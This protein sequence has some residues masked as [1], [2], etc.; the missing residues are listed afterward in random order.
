MRLRLTFILPF[1]MLT[2]AIL[3][4]EYDPWPVQQLRLIVFDTYQRLKP[5]SFDAARSPVRVIDINDASLAK[6]G[7]W[8]W[9]RTTLAKMVEDLT[10]KGAAAIAFDVVFAEPDDRSPDRIAARLPDRPE[11]KEVKAALSAFPSNDAVFAKAIAK[12]RVVLAFAPVSGRGNGAVKSKAGFAFAGMNPNRFVP[13]YA[14]AVA[15]LPQ[16]VAAATG[17]GSI[18]FKPDR[19][20]II[21]KVPLFIEIGGK[22]LPTLGAEALRVAQGAPSY[23]IKSVGASGELSFGAATGVVAARIGHF[24]VPTDGT[25]GVVM[26]YAPTGHARIIPAWRLVE[27][28]VKRGEVEGRIVFI[29]ASAS[30]LK[31]IRASALEAAI[32]GVEIQA[33]LVEQI[34]GGAYLKVPDFGKGL[35]LGYMFIVG[36]T[37]LLLLPR[38]GPVYSGFV[39][40]LA[41]A[42]AVGFSWFAFAAWGW[43]LDPVYPSITVF[44][45]A[46]T[47]TIVVYLRSEAERR[48][49]RGAFSRYMSPELVEQLADNPERLKLGGENRLMSLMFCDIR[50]FTGISESFRDAAELTSFINRFLTPMTELILKRRGIIDK[51]MGDAIMAF[52]NAPLD[53]PRHAENACR[54]ALDMV[55]A[56]EVLND[57][58]AAEAT[59]QERAFQRVRIGI[60][61]NTGT[62]CVG[63]LGSE[64]RFDYSVIG[65]EV[66]LASRLEGLCKTYGVDIILGE[67]THSGA[68]GFATMEL[69]R[70]RVVGRQQPTRIYTLLGDPEHADDK[71]IREMAEAQAALLAAYRACKW[72]EARDCLKRCRDLASPR[73]AG[74]YDVFAARIAGFEREP[75]PAGWDGVYDATSK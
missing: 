45:V 34:I 39:G 74:L 5:R 18:G 10:A 61:I 7:Q 12:G 43:L 71:A 69:D 33:Q 17:Y 59:A 25:S 1:A 23:L 56:L 36:L 73:I 29:G 16:L 64:L 65:D 66:N 48:Q 72:D 47:G 49:V 50:G 44:L 11:L 6:I 4:R 8:P 58:W 30:A 60:G 55:R 67:N 22:L 35:E 68:P 52:W 31:D 14:G 26:Y 57:E 62:A 70:V 32:P 51:Y 63:N 37:V 38:V 54:A 20:L 53:D 42:G 41:I 27:G 13:G 75:P 24:T 46:L 2:A 40:A 21:R 15:A 19:D 28:K 9:P 3:L